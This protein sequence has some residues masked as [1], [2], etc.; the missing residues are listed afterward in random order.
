M[1]Q[2]QETMAQEYNKKRKMSPHSSKGTV[3]G[4]VANVKLLP[5]Q[6][7]PYWDRPYQVVVIKAHDLSVIQVDQPWLVDVPVDCLG[8]TVNSARSTMPLNYT[9]EVARVPS[10]SQEETYYMEKILGHCIQRKRLHFNVHWEGCTK[11]WDTEGST[12][13]FSPCYKKVWRESHSNHWHPRQPRWTPLMRLP[14]KKPRKYVGI[15]LFGERKSEREEMGD[16]MKRCIHGARQSYKDPHQSRASGTA[17][18][19]LSPKG[20]RVSGLAWRDT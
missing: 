2:V 5:K 4:P 14:G 9:T 15:L 20:L 6:I 10:K 11:G 13:S 17:P 12:E 8:K 7:I 1:I 19:P 16:N 18:P 3:G